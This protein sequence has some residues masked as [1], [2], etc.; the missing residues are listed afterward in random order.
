MI[1]NSTARCRRSDSPDRPSSPSCIRRRS[2]TDGRPRTSSTIRRSRC[3]WHRAIPGVPR[4][5]IRL[6]M[7][8]GEQTVIDMARKLGLSTPIPPYP[9]IH[10]GAADVYPIE[11]I[12]AYSAFATLGIQAHALGIV[13]VENAQGEVLWAPESVK[14]P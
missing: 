1:R 2:R 9:S 7:E 6:G 5:T 13:R 8:L 14:V 12:S 4:T 11:L 10:I 3:R